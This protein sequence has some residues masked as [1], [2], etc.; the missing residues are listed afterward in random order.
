[1]TVALY[2]SQL[3]PAG[4]T[5]IH[6]YATEI[7]RALISLDPDRYRMVTSAEDAPPI[8][9]P[10]DIPVTRLPGPRRVLHLSWYLAHRPPIERFI[11]TTDLVH[12][13]SPTFPVP[14]RAPIVYTIHDL[15][16]IDDASAFRRRE[17]RLGAAALRDAARR[18]RRIITVSEAVAERTVALLGVDRARISVVHHGIGERFH[19]P[20]PDGVVGDVTSRYGVEAGRYL[21][22]VGKV[23]DR[24]NVT[25]LVR[26]IA[27]RGPGVRLVVTGPPGFGAGNVT[28]E[29][30]RLGLSAQIVLTGHVPDADLLPLMAGAL[31]LVHPSEFEGFG[32]TPLE[33][34]ALGTPAIASRAGSL[35]EVLGDGA[36]L[37]EP[38][39][40]NAWADAMSRVERDAAFA[41]DLGERGRRHASR[42]TW[43]RAAK[44]TAAVHDEVTSG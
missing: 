9:F 18:A 10:H 19:V 14:S 37:L 21:L 28:A 23:E 42:F 32:F 39:D 43:E 5:G 2:V 33:A 7:A 30:E 4:P 3:A 1:M 38:R 36:L 13:L 6:R 11:G 29:I 24:K 22:Y 15:Q 26:A 35:P 16:H 31:A 25:T 34:M 44:E 17:A 8:W 40:A 12:V 20:A 27:K 41:R